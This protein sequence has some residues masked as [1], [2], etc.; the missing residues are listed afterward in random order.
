[1]TNQ[2]RYT[3][4]NEWNKLLAQGGIANFVYRDWG[5]RLT[6]FTGEIRSPQ[7]EVYTFEFKEN[8]IS[9][10]L[11]ILQTK[12]DDL[13]RDE[14]LLGQ[15]LKGQSPKGQSPKGQS[16]KGQ[17]L[18][19]QSLKG[20][21]LKGQSLKG[22]SLK[23]QSLK[24]QSLK[25]QPSKLLGYEI[26]TCLE[27][28]LR[29]YPLSIGTIYLYNEYLENQENGWVLRLDDDAYY[30][31]IYSNPSLP[32]EPSNLDPLLTIPLKD[33]QPTLNQCISHR[34][35]VEPISAYSPLRYSFYVKARTEVEQLIALTKTYD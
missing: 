17:S 23:G 5:I 16:P 34:I 7:N 13:I 25:G 32:F 3:D 20:Q 4:W 27:S 9:L 6:I 1:M 2:P 22:Q 19:G 26:L 15:S 8:D 21:S 10:H 31:N 14:R 28:I 35:Q 24:G 11:Q 18:K 30:G 33:L 29:E 12:I